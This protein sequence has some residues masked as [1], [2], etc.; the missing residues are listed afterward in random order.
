MSSSVPEVLAEIEA[1][2]RLQQ[3]EIRVDFS[4]IVGRGVAYAHSIA[5][6]GVKNDPHPGQFRDSIH[7]EDLPD[8]DGLPAARILSDD[9]NAGYIEFGTVKTP[10]HGTF[11]KTRVY[12]EHEGADASGTVWER[13]D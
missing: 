9:E 12:L 8:V 6:I 7:S 4:A 3:A 10:E 2:V 11:A 1:Q 5:P 13:F